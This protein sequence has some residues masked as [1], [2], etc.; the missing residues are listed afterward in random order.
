MFSFIK[1]PLF[2]YLLLASTLLTALPADSK[3]VKNIV[4]V[5]GAY[6]DGSSWSRVIPILQA[7]GHNVTAVQQPLSSIPD[8]VA[9]TNAALE[10]IEGPIVLVGHS[11]GG[12]VITEASYNNPKISALV[13]VAAFAPDFN[14]SA[15]D[16][17]L[18]YPLPPVATSLVTDSQ[19]RQTILKDK[20]VQYFCPDVKSICKVLATA[21]G[22]SDQGRY[23]YK[24][25]QPGWKQHPNYY[26]VAGNDHII[27]PQLEADTAVRIKAVKTIKV[28]GSS[29]AVLVSHPQVVADIIMEAANAKK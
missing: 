5:H 1:T 11:F 6:A 29:H 10:Q 21:Q 27:N 3:P 23:I 22:P 8:D 17:M 15:L 12:S 14:Q 4:L 19:G 18:K 16:M 24:S 26:V 13:Y 2:G 28:A 7:A 20:F 25:G 9:K